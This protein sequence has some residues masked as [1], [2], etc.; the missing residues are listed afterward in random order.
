MRLVVSW[1]RD[2]VDV[3]ASPEEIAGRIGLRGFEVASIERLPDGDA[4]IDFEVTANRPDCLSV[5]GLAR[6]VA[7]AFDLPLAAPSYDAGARIRLASLPAGGP[8]RLPVSIEDP[9]LCPRYAA[10]VAEVTQEPSPAWLAR[11][12]QAA[13]V[14]PISAIVDITNYVNLEL[15]Q[16]MHAFDLAKLAGPRIRVRRAKPGERLKTLDGVDRPLD[17]EM[18]VIA[19]RDRA[20]AVAGVMGGADSEISSATRLVAFESAYF[21]PASV[22]RTSKR[23]GLK[24]EASFRFERGGD[25]AAQVLALERAAALMAEL[26]AGSI[27]GGAIDCHPAP[28]APV[29]LRLRRDRLARLFGAAVPDAD[30]ERILRGLGLGVTRIAGGWDVAVPS[31]RVDLLREADLIEEVGRHYGFDKL[32]PTFPS[33]SAPA[34]PPDARTEQHRL[35]RRVLTS[36]GLSEAVTFGFIEARAAE[37]FGQEAAIGIANPLSAKFDT[38]RPL[39]LPGLVDALAHNRRHGRQDVR[40]FEIGTRFGPAGE[41][42]AVAV[43][44]TGAAAAEHW[45]APARAVDFF[46]IKGVVGELCGAL[47]VAVRFTPGGDGFL[48]PG[49]SAAVIAGDAVVGQVGQLSP[50]IADARGLPRRDRIMVAELDLDGLTAA[51]V[52]GS[53]ATRPLP[54]YPFVVRDVSIVVPDTLPAEI[55]HGTIQSAGRGLAAPLVA[56]SVFDRYQGKGVPDGSVSLSI[57]LTFQSEDRTLTDAEVQQAFE[58]ILAA[59]VNEHGAVQR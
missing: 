50:S 3:A 38:L 9:D 1:L 32:E 5:R 35:V 10:A 8:E 2:F 15:G 28:A 56:T 23:L 46:D 31:F 21:K 27:V 57:R 41:T 44:W 33:V 26:G 11:R 42:R 14:R 16:P 13:G 12:I 34:P 22:R 58:T 43:A 17:P 20:Q 51:R 29:A 54:R 24:T 55:I 52:A 37:L 48:V 7:T 18:L 6:E 40:L 47:R 30:V 45:S 59:L 25:P 53:D 49:Q 36:T 19:D 39:L 4:V